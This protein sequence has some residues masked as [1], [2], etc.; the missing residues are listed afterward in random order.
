MKELECEADSRKRVA[1]GGKLNGV[2]N[3]EQRLQLE[4]NIKEQ[5]T[6]LNGYQKVHTQNSL[7]TTPMSRNNEVVLSAMPPLYIIQYTVCK[8]C[9]VH[10]CCVYQLG[11]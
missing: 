7:V 2:I 6:L 10:S 9:I 8:A 3:E 1:S 5:E 11:E 4:Q